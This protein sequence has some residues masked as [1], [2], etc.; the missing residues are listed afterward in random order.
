M[1]NRK[2]IR[3]FAVLFVLL[4]SASLFSATAVAAAGLYVPIAPQGA[5]DAGAQWS[6][7]GGA[8]WLNN[9]DTFWGVGG[10]SYTVTFKDITGGWTTPDSFSSGPLMDGQTIY[11]TICIFRHSDYTF[12]RHI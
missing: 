7:D 4:C 6:A 5:I 9:G 8:T 2:S 12:R 10:Q 11:F 3:L 1:C